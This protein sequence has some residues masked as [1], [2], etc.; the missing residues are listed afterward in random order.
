MPPYRVG[1]VGAQREPGGQPVPDPEDRMHRAL[2]GRCSHRQVP[3]LWELLVD[4]R[5]DGRH[6]HGQ[7]VVVY[8]HRCS[9]PV[10]DAV[11]PP[12]FPDR[13]QRHRDPTWP[14]GGG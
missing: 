1:L 11:V 2:P 14:A 3:P 12:G 8:P 6:R 10:V 7:L 13:R 4:E 5:A 9:V